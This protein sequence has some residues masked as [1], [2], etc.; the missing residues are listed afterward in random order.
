[1]A[2]QF[3][4]TRYGAPAMLM[5]LL[6]GLVFHFLTENERLL[7]GVELAATGFLRLGVALLGFRLTIDQVTTLG[8]MPVIGVCFAVIA[9]LVFGYGLAK[10]MRLR[11]H[12]GT[13]TGGAVAICGASAAMAI[14][15]VLPNSDHQRRDTVFTVVG[16]T[17]LSTTV[18]VLYPLISHY[19]GLTDLQ[20]SLFL[21]A[22]IHDVAQVVGAGYS[23]S[24]EV[25]DLSTFVKLLRVAMLAPV[26]LIIGLL[27][28]RRLAAD[29]GDAKPTPVPGFLLAFCAAFL[30]NSLGV[31]PANG[32]RIASDAATWLLLIAITALGIRTS[33]RDVADVGLRPIVLMV[34]ETVFLALLMLGI[35]KLT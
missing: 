32:A 5:G 9:T 34:S 12:L 22:T 17:T 23:V 19:L 24:E 2:A 18:M 3:L 26:V 35:T 28:R 7:P 10:L 20:T 1:M 6:L 27:A 30:L 11:G 15:S 16:V 4:S 21:G 8:L 31:I 13:L 25:G 14:S 29:E 33:L